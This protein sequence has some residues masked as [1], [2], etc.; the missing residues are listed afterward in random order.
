MAFENGVVAEYRSDVIV[1]LYE[2]NG[3]RTE[4]S[5]YRGISLFRVCL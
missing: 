5:S 4:C 2:G 1:P 3:E